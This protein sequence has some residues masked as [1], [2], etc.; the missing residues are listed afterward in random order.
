MSNR[1]RETTEG[2]TLSRRRLLSATA[3]VGTAAVTPAFVGGA[4]AQ[5]DSTEN[6][7][8]PV[9]VQNTAPKFGRDDYVGQFVQVS[10]YDREASKQG[11]GSCEFVGSDADITGYDAE[12]IDTYNDDHRSEEIT[13]F[14]VTTGTNVQPGKLFVVNEQSQCSGGYV[15]LQLEEVGSSSIETPGQSDGTGGSSGS[16][17]E[18][19]GFGVLAGLLGVGAAGAAAARSGSD[20]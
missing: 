17:S 8:T 10:G 6:K 13:M 9:A 4:A 3:A 2:K 19:P 14:A 20:D 11:V 18:I 12:M 5:S 15:T 16:S 1:P 7:D